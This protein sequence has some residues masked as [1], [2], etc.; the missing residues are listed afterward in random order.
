MELNFFTEN[1]MQSD[2]DE[3]LPDL[4]IDEKSAECDNVTMDVDSEDSL[5]DIGEEMMRRGF[6]KFAT[7]EMN[8]QDPPDDEISGRVMCE[9]SSEQS[10]INETFQIS[11]QEFSTRSSS[12]PS[13]NMVSF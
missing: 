1:T 10:I 11:Q 3:L 5:M 4:I 6:P 7:I 12:E 13:D 8:E 9:Q 2:L